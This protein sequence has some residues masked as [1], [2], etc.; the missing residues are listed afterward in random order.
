MVD[1]I[2]V[3]ALEPVPTDLEFIKFLSGGWNDTLTTNQVDARVL[4]T[5]GE[6]NRLDFDCLIH[7]FCG[8]PALS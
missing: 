2:L 5:T 7:D 8:A 1:E 3:D 4:V 6:R